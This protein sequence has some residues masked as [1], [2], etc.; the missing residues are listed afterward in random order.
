VLARLRIWQTE[1]KVKDTCRK[2]LWGAERREPPTDIMCAA[3]EIH[4]QQFG[5]GAPSTRRRSSPRR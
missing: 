3:R 2:G 1:R 5:F 4:C